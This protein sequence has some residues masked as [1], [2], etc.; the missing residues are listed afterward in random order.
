MTELAA[1]KLVIVARVVA[2]KWVIV[3]MVLVLIGRLDSQHCVARIQAI[4][5]LQSPMFL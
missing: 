3:V 4:L 1:E 2:G 5:E